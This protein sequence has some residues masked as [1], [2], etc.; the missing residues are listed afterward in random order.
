M[1]RH[2]AWIAAFALVVAS[3]TSTCGGR[4]NGAGGPDV[5][6]GDPRTCEPPGETVRVAGR[7]A[8]FPPSMPDPRSCVDGAP[9]SNYVMP[10][11]ALAVD[12]SE[13]LHV[14]GV[15]EGA[16]PEGTSR[17][18]DEH[19]QGVVGVTIEGRP[20]PVA[21]FLDAYEP[22]RWAITLEP[23]ASLS[24][25]VTHGYYDQEVTGVPSDVPVTH[26]GP[27]DDYSCIYG[28]EVAANLGGCDYWTGIRT[29]RRLTA[30]T[31]TS[32]QGCYAGAD[33]TVPR[34]DG[35]APP[36]RES[37]V[38][39]DESRPREDVA[40]PGCAAVVA[41]REYCLTTSDGAI[42]LLG[43]DSGR[44]CPVLQ[45]TAIPDAPETH[46]IAWR[47]EVLYVCTDDG[48]VRISLRDGASEALQL[49]CEAVADADGEILVL[50]SYR[51]PL[52]WD[53]PLFGEVWAYPSYAALLSGAT[54]RTYE[55]PASMRMTATRERL[56]GASFPGASVD[57]REL[58]SGRA[59]DPLHLE[60]YD[61]FIF[62][63]A[64]TGDGE[65][66][67]S[68]PDFGR[69]VVVFDARTGERLRDLALD[70]SVIGL[71][72]VSGGAGG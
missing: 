5:M 54:D 29:I 62:G 24:R 57:V 68:G 49:P 14:I 20:R 41:E 25:V 8:D 71:S 38:T 13:E 16:L 45:T 36:C 70:R 23:G 19:P 58:P 43:L 66:V 55:L 37:V 34:R 4:G 3:G 1:G 11:A 50:P 22:V 69:V 33:F 42:A 10:A 40:F 51:D 17:G 52:A 6:P 61:D 35:D 72:C 48:L 44:V 28:W 63:M 56:Y 46:S 9:P 30:L 47:G 53:G 32:F 60:G 15:Y 18:F 12:A 27:E 2:G 65:L 7:R 64:A 26:L 31:E 39:G 21:L 67:V 59:L